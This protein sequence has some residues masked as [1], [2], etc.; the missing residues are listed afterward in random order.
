MDINL[1]I[2][3]KR[4]KK[5]ITLMSLNFNRTRNHYFYPESGNQSYVKSS[6]AKKKDEFFPPEI[7][8]GKSD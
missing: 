8:P 1:E 7:R 5:K 2:P 6:R 4:P 3:P